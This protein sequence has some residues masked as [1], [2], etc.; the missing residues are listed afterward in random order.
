M[1]PITSLELVLTGLT[2]TSAGD[3]DIYLIDPYGISLEIM[4]DEATA[5]ALRM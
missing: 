3:L 5:S 1:G 4:T 2:H